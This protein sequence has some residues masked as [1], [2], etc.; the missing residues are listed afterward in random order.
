MFQTT[1]PCECTFHLTVREVWRRR[2]CMNVYSKEAVNINRHF[3]NLVQKFLKRALTFSF[4]ETR[5]KLQW[6][7][8]Q[9]LKLQTNMEQFICKKNETMNSILGTL[10]R[11]GVNFTNFLCA[12]FALIFFCQ[13]NT[14]SNS[15]YKKA[16][17]YTFVC[18]S[19]S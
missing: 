17:Q 4:C 1:F 15:K 18:K 19:C 6:K 14:K 7:C 16:A 11:L 8:D 2:V 9:K 5:I 12:A 13:K 10:K 3:K